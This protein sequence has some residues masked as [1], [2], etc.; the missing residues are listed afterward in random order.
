VRHKLH[1]SGLPAEIGYLSVSTAAVEL[2]CL[3]RDQGAGEDD[4]LLPEIVVLDVLP[5]VMRRHC[6]HGRVLTLLEECN[7]DPTH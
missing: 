6:E 1:D 2:Q 3:N 5:D 7:Q 4:S